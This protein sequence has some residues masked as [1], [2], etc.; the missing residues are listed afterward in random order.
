LDAAQTA[1]L[2]GSQF[3]SRLNYRKSSLVIKPPSK[4]VHNSSPPFG[5]KKGGIDENRNVI[6]DPEANRHL[7]PLTPLTPLTP[8]ESDSDADP[9]VVILVSK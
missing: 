9:S 5:P 6:I 7:Q 8:V 3:E 4:R 1:K 2:G